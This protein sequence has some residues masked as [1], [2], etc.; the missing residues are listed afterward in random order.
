MAEILITLLFPLLFGVGKRSKGENN[1]LL[2]FPH[3]CNPR[4]IS[5]SAFPY[6]YFFIK[7][8]VSKNS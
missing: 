8:G 1:K 3:T 5:L 4:R 7:R 6:I 2:R